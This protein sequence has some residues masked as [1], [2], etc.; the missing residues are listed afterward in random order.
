MMGSRQKLEPKLFYTQVNLEERVGPEHPLR[1]VLAVV[2]F[3]FVR[4][5]VKPLYGR[6]G[7]ESIDPVVVLKLMFLSFYENLRS[8]RAVAAQL[9]LRLDWLWFCG[10]DLDERTPHHSVISKARRRWGKP[11]FEGFFARVLAACVAA[12]LVDGTVVH[13]D[14]SLIAGNASRDRL[15]LCLRYVGGRVYDELEQ[16]TFGEGSPSPSASSPEPPSVP[17]PEPDPAK[18]LSEPATEAVAPPYP[19]QRTTPVDP[20]ARL[21]SKNGDTT[22]GYKDHRAVDDRSGIVTATETTA[23]NVN[24]ETMLAAVLEAHEANTGSTVKRVAADKA[25]GTGENYR[26]LHERGITPCIPHKEKNCHRDRDLA[27]ARFIY[28]PATDT[29][30]CPGGRTLSRRQFHQDKNAVVYEASRADCQN[31]IHFG[32]CVT[33]RTRGRRVSRNLNDPHIE[34]ADAC[35]A[36]WQRKR[37]M[38]RRKTKAEGSFADAENNHSF[39]RARWRGLEGA[40]IQ[41]LLIAAI[42]NLRK[43][44]RAVFAKNGPPAAGAR[45]T[46]AATPFFT[47]QDAFGGVSMVRC[48]PAG[49]SGRFLSPRRRIRQDNPSRPDGPVT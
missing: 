5:E 21:A 2:D 29:V 26:H 32:R 13:V 36:P 1:R 24:D 4:R 7:H 37:L 33:S 40:G 10:Y 48:D 41:N 34:W 38:A 16:A 20:D 46:A 9:P 11:V 12:G 39:K 45:I 17:T 35:L 8:E 15:E 47:A 14:S 22:L 23:A 30:R 19:G 42:Q 25:Y 28:D 18:A 49:R 27:N 3:D 6:N 43:L 31:C 44:V